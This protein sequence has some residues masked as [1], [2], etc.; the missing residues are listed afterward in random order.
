MKRRGDLDKRVIQLGLDEN[1]IKNMSEIWK[2][3]ISF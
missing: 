3:D 2:K 1:L